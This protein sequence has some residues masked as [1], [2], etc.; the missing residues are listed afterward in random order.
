MR[1]PPTS[2]SRSDQDSIGRAR[3]YPLKPLA[4][5]LL[6]IHPWE[7]YSRRVGKKGLEW[8][9]PTPDQFSLIEVI[10][11]IWRNGRNAHLTTTY[12]PSASIPRYGKP[13]VAS[14]EGMSFN[15]DSMEPEKFY[16]VEYEG[17]RYAVRLTK[18]GT[19]ETYEI[20]ESE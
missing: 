8:M 10:I 9:S 18:D 7:G 20:E 15:L 11:S 17:E 5:D 16:L 14:R 19:L 2:T 6:E 12:T 3:S 13:V 1:G 4:Q